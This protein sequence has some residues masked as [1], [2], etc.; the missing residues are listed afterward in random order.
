MT[1]LDQP[2]AR[3]PVRSI[4][5]AVGVITVAIATALPVI[6]SVL[7]LRELRSTAE[8]NLLNAASMAAVQAD[9]LLIEQFFELELLAAS[10]GDSGEEADLLLESVRTVYGRLASLS[11]GVLWFDDRGVAVFAE[12]AES[13]DFGTSATKITTGL[14]LDV[15]SVSMPFMSPSTGY[16]AAALSVPVYRDDGSREGT[17]V[18]L[19][20]LTEP[21][22]TDLVEPARVL[23]ATGH[24][25]LVDERGLVLASTS[26]SHVLQRGDHP[27]L[28]DAVAQ[29]R[30]PIVRRV[31]HHVDGSSLDQSAWHVMAYAPLRVAPWGVA[32]GASEVEIL[33]P[34]SRL[35]SQFVAI[36]AASL[37]TLIVGGLF[38]LGLARR[39]ERT[40]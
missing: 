4:A 37:V 20:D 12:P 27:D 31:A 23:G 1:E 17:L 22:V 15:R 21:L 24:A 3:R 38:A 13:T 29:N 30:A 28:Y 26:P 39:S 34:V 32:M 40:G 16:V 8:S 36:G 11:S 10:I 19:L 9:R 5:F 33:E 35:Q 6:A 18:G 2:A 14:R 25:D 7:A